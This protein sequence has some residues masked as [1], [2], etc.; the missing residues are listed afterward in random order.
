MLFIYLCLAVLGLHCHVGYSPVAA[1]GLL[2]AVVS[3]VG[4]YRLEDTQPPVAVVCG[5]SRCGSQA[6]QRRLNSCG[7]RA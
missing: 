7:A 1:H 5:L 6:L 3:L 4:E 2:V